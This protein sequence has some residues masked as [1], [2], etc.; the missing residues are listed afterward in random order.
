M[1]P[2]RFLAPVRTLSTSISEFGD[3]R[4]DLPGPCKRRIVSLTLA[5]ATPQRCVNF[6]WPGPLQTCFVRSSSA[7]AIRNRCVDLDSPGPLQTHIDRFCTARAIRNTCRVYFGFRMCPNLYSVLDWPG[8]CQTHFG[9][10]FF[11]PHKGQAKHVS[12]S[13]LSSS[14]F[15]F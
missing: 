14:V 1:P 9:C 8:P 5:R 3:V 12:R 4:F 2:S 6:D 11:T 7:R 10:F 13:S 15:P